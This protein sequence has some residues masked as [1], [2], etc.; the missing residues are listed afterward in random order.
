MF[1]Q[2]D[3]DQL[4]ENIQQWSDD[5][6]KD[7]ISE[8]NALEV[9]RYPYSQNPVPLKKALKRSLRKKFGLTDRISYSMPRSA[10]FLHKGVSRS[11]GK[12]NPRKAKE[13]YEPVVNRN[14]DSLSDIVADGQGSLVINSLKIK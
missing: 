4:N 7:L 10:I 13:W 11:H 12:S 14:I 3:I 2:K 9:K 8:L 6:K 5:N 1:E